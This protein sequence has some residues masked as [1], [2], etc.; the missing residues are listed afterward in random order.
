[1][2]AL[3]EELDVVEVVALLEADREFSGTEGVS[4]VP[5]IGDIATIVHV[6]EMGS[7]FIAEAVNE[8]GLTLWVA[9]FQ[10]KELQLRAKYSAQL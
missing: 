1:M 2:N 9:D 7:L 8:Q 4:R 6:L 10:A 3:I 5:R